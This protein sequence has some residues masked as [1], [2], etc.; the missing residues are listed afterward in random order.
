MASL[1]SPSFLA[2]ALETSHK[3][4]TP[5]RHF[6]PPSPLLS[7]SPRR[8]ARAA[9]RCRSWAGTGELPAPCDPPRAGASPRRAAVRRVISSVGAPVEWN[10]P[11]GAA[12]RRG[13]RF[14][15]SLPCRG[16]GYNH[17]C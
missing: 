17:C 2:F 3:L 4:S 7:P 16:S 15:P 12:R 11:S 1:S 9:A 8:R 13:R 14:R 6:N 10:P 5:G